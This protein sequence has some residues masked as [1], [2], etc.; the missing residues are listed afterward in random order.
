[1]TIIAARSTLKRR[2]IASLASLSLVYNNRATRDEKACRGQG[3]HGN[4]LC[5]TRFIIRAQAVGYADVNH[6][7]GW[8]AI[9]IGRQVQHCNFSTSECLSQVRSWKMLRCH[10]VI[11]VFKLV[12]IEEIYVES[13]GRVLA[14]QTRETIAE[15][16]ESISTKVSNRHLTLNDD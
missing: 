14:V 3:L 13:Q 4:S 2:W 15:Y 7:V 12:W 5:K 6:Q 10:V 9:L 16:Y 1:M 8:I 11:R